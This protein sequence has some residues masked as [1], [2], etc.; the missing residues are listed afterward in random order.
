MYPSA[1]LL[2]AKKEN[3]ECLEVQ[4]PTV[5]EPPVQGHA[6]CTMRYAPSVVRIQR[7]HSNRVTGDRF[8]AMIVIRNGNRQKDT[9]YRGWQIETLPVTAS[10]SS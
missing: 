7:S 5:Q 3:R 4:E 8:I 9:N 1:V 6:R 10:E 2:A